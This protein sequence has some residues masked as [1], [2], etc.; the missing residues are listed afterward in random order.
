MMIFSGPLFSY[1]GGLAS[2]RII[3][4]YSSDW[5]SGNL[6]FLRKGGMKIKEWKDD[7]QRPCFQEELPSDA[8]QAFLLK[9]SSAMMGMPM[10]TSFPHG[11]KCN[12]HPL[13]LKASRSRDMIWAKTLFSLLFVPSDDMFSYHTTLPDAGYV[14]AS[15]TSALAELLERVNS[16]SW[17]ADSYALV[18]WS[19]ESKA[20]CRK[21]IGK[22]L[23]DEDGN[24]DGEAAAKYAYSLLYRGL[25]FS[26]SGG[27]PLFLRVG[28]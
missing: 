8:Y 5:I 12:R 24:I 26:L 23:P 19:D 18:S 14:L 2:E 4:D 9:A 20:D 1:L 16:C 22:I 27:T 15:S 11:F 28:K 7:P 25:L 10:L 3:Q 6:A 13:V 21:I 17:C